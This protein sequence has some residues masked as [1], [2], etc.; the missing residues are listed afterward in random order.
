MNKWLACFQYALRHRITSLILLLLIGI[1][2]ICDW[3]SGWQFLDS[4]KTRWDADIS[5]LVTFATFFV[6]IAVWVAELTQEWRNQLPKRLTVNFVYQDNDGSRTVMTCEQAHLSDIA[7]I[8]ALGQQIGMQLVNPDDPKQLSFRA[9]Y[10][11]QNEGNIEHSLSIGFF[12][13]FTVEFTLTKLPE[14]LD[15]TECRCWVA[16]FDKQSISICQ[17]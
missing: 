10:V 9:P 14:G 17:P 3:Q 6:A 7:D 15:A 16:P 5:Q 1:L 13:H 4:V 8:R 12:R 2:L 11:T